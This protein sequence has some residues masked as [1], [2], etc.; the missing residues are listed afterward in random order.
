MG[1]ISFL[2]CCCI[3]AGKDDSWVPRGLMPVPVFSTAGVILTADRGTVVGK[4]HC[5][6]SQ[7]LLP[8]LAVLPNH[9]T[10][11]PLIMGGWEVGGIKRYQNL[12]AFVKGKEGSQW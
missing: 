9:M 5:L 2:H 10:F 8:V 4:R 6:R 7:V 3:V 1:M 11:C 12:K